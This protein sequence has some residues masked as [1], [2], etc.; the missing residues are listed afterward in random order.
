MNYIQLYITFNFWDILNLVTEQDKEK[1]VELNPT[2]SK[3][4]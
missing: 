2:P 4:S 3:F 1:G